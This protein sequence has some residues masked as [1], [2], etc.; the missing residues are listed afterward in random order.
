MSLLFEQEK[1]WV[2]TKYYIQKIFLLNIPISYNIKLNLF[3]YNHILIFLFSKNKQDDTY[4]LIL[5][6]TKQIYYSDINIHIHS[7]LVKFIIIQILDEKQML[8]KTQ[9]DKS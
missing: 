4:I 5:K 8:H 7:D 6:R 2:G 9:A 1:D 3:L